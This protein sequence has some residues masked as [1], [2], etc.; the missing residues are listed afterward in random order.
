MLNNKKTIIATTIFISCLTVYTMSSMYVFTKS[1]SVTKY[2]IADVKD[3]TFTYD[4]IF[5]AGYEDA[6]CSVKDAYGNDVSL[7]DVQ[8]FFVEDL[9]VTDSYGN[10]FVK[11]KKYYVSMSQDTSGGDEDGVITYKLASAKVDDKCFVCPYFYDKDGNEI[12]Y[13]YYGKYKG[14]VADSKLCSKSG[15]VPTYKGTID[16]Y[17]SYARANGNQYHQ[18]DWCSVF[19]A[20]IMFMCAYKTTKFEAKVTSRESE[21]ETGSGTQVLGIEDIVGNGYEIVDG[22]QIRY[23]AN[24]NLDVVN[25]SWE[26]KISAYSDNMTNN[27]VDIGEYVNGYSAYY[28]KHMNYVNGSPVLSL[29]PKEFTDQA[30]QASSYKKYYCDK[31]YFD[32]S[33]EENPKFVYWGSY[34]ST[35][36]VTGLFLLNCNY[37][38]TYWSSLVG[39]RLHT[40][41]LG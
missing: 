20:Q 18:T 1:A 27:T 23:T 35:K 39:S 26:N 29:F 32:N 17:R 41:K 34:A 15:V 13:A 19:T 12:G 3:R 7:T 25:V 38:W 22:L 4:I 31:F 37:N 11:L 2:A 33:S 30:S 8:N 24:T 9:D 10:H 16:T 6:S 36:Y 21:S 28:I 14:N 5:K 40:K